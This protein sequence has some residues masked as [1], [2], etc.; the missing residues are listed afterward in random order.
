MDAII[1]VSS[2][3]FNEELFKKIGNLLKGKNADI[4]IAV[5]EIS[6]VPFR[7]ET[8]E[9][10]WNRLHKSV[11]DIEQGKG[12]TFTMKELEEFITK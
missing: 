9:E 2:S 1:K 3:E 10:Y 8:T 7:K 5:T 6:D 11:E 4:T 12:I